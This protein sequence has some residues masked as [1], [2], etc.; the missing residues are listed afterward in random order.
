MSW[1]GF[2][3]EQTCVVAI[4]VPG[5]LGGYQTGAVTEGKSSW[6]L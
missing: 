2:R 6:S 4:G 3:Q 1:D 5:R